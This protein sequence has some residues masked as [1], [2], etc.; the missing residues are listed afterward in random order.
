MIVPGYLPYYAV[1][2][3]IGIIIAVLFGLGRALA[4][5][6]WA[7]RERSRV[8]TAIGFALVT[9]FL[10]TA[11]LAW[12]G[13]YRGA[14]DRIPTIQFGIFLPILI[15][16]LVYRR[17]PS[18]ARL[19]D[20]VPQQWLVGVQLYRALGAIFVVLFA[21]GSLPGLFALPAGVG[22]LAVGL[23]APVVALACARKPRNSAGSVLA[24]NMFGIGDLVVAVALGFATAPS[25]LQLAALDN[26]NVLISAFPLVLIPVFLVPL[27]ILLHLASLAKLR[28]THSQPSHR[29]HATVARA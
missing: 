12:L 8:I 27:S 4:N 5:A 29:T 18:V 1:L 24:W 22:D 15:G 16:V 21:T 28:R 26:P 13:V 3:G 19:V 9:W 20:A 10:A 2:G 25:P 7:A 11:V 14:A 17:F 6:T 23:L